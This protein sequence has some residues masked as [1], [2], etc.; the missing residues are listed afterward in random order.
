M[1]RGAQLAAYVERLRR[2]GELDRIRAH[3]DPTTLALFERPPLASDWIPLRHNIAIFAAVEA[4][5]G[6]S[7]VRALAYEASRDAIDV[8]TRPVLELTLTAFGASPST[9]LSRANILLRFS[10]RGQELTYRERT[11][12]SGSLSI[13]VVGLNAPASFFEAW[14]GVTLA[15]IDLCGAHGTATVTRVEARGEDAL[16][17]LDVAWE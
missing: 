9:L 14:C 15:T 8:V 5:L 13:F 11:P 16:G 3:V 7:R 10:V 4:T 17:E 12:K 2:W 6:L 1:T